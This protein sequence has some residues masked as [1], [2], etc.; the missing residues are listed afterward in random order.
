MVRMSAQQSLPL[1]T[2]GGKRRN[3]GRPP[4]SHRASE[5]HTTRE[6]FTRTTPAHV[7]LRVVERVGSM[8]RRAA[9][10][11]IRLATASTLARTD[12][13]IVHLSLERDHLHLIVEADHQPALSAGVKAFASSAAQR[14]NRA[15]SKSARRRI[16]GT[17]FADRFHA[18]LVK[19]PTQARHAIAYVL[20]NWRR[21]QQDQDIDTMFWDVDYFSSGPSF[22]GW[23]ELAH[24][25]F[26]VPPTYEPLPVA[27]P[28]TWL[29]AHGW[30][31]AGT[32]SWQQ[33][34]RATA[35]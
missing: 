1:H 29:L 20:N 10:H 15:L 4:R 23:R 30:R 32:I 22:D 24:S 12:F 25:T 7:T 9:Y 2:W 5:P 14:L 13:R 26:E 16:R 28:Q 34:P 18:R 35:R 6:R 17:V 31:K 21:H 11:A 27:R 33:V 8:R 3:A 19:S